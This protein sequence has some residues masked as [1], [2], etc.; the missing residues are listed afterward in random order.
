MIM[1][2]D[3]GR[4]SLIRASLVTKIFVTFDI[5]SFLTQAAGG[6]IFAQKNANSAKI[7]KDLMMAG[8]IIQIIA[9]VGFLLISIIYTV[10]F[11]AS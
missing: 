3:G 2:V 10:I 11:I 8:L 4:H 5:L 7:G 9:F 1:K 6:A